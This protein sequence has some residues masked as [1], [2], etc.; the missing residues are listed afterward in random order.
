MHS[1]H[2]SSLLQQRTW[3]SLWRNIA[4][5]LGCIC[6]GLCPA[7][8]AERATTDTTLAQE[9]V[10]AS[11]M[12]THYS[13]N[14]D[15]VINELAQRYVKTL[16]QGQQDVTLFT[17]ARRAVDQ[18]CL[19]PFI[20]YIRLRQRYEY[21]ELPN[22]KMAQE[23][24]AVVDA[25][26]QA[27]YPPLIRAY[28][29][30]RALTICDAVWGNRDPA[31]RQRLIEM[32][33][34]ATLECIEADN[35]DERLTR[36]LVEMLNDSYQNSKSNREAAFKRIDAAL[37]RRFGDCA[38]IHLLRG[39]RAIDRAWEARGGGYANTVTQEAWTT[40]GRELLTAS[41]ELECAWQLDPKEVSIAENMI[42]VCM[43]LGLPRN[44]ME[45]WFNKGIAT[46]QDGSNLCD[47]K[48]Y[49]LAARWHGSLEQQLEFARECL[50]HPEYG[51]AAVLS[52]WQT[53]KSHQ[54]VNQLPRSYYAQP[55]V[56]NDIKQSFS[57]YFQVYPDAVPLRMR[58]AYHA[59]L[60][61]DWKT[62][63][64][65]LARADPNVTDMKEIGGRAVYDQM[66]AG[67]K[68]HQGKPEKTSLAFMIFVLIA[69]GGLL[70]KLVKQ[71]AP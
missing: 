10:S 66:A 13:P 4:S 32:R 14:W 2:S 54:S 23:S 57:K 43:G 36:P 53:H 71:R 15:V 18:G 17:Q 6:L 61:K 63:S 1:H 52:L 62:L 47:G 40:F 67:A 34:T 39:K 38:S 30:A 16:I 69:V 70:Y 19:D 55:A 5:L 49:Y 9:L 12:D 46:G 68:K 22:E 24:V 60:A 37:I 11:K 8:A 59:W 45:E 41:K 7:L 58:Y 65:Q 20:R 28:A 26:H 64:E 29:L 42:T 51:R 31:T 35:M 3:P 50:Q 27:H 21:A 44:A 48:L 25:L 33:W 56:W